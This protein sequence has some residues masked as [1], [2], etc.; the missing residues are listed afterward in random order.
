MPQYDSIGKVVEA[1]EGGELGK[2]VVAV[3]D[4]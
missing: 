2:K 3:G 4:G 1:K